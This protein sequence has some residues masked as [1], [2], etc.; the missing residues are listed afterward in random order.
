MSFEVY[1]QCFR[2]GK[3][4]GVP[5]DLI[6]P[7]F[8]VIE[9]ESEPDY[10]KV[11]YDESDWCNL[12]ITPLASDPSL[13]YAICAWRPCGDRRFWSSILSVMRLGA[14]ALYWPNSPPLIASRATE[15]ELPADMIECLGECRVVDEI[16][17]IYATLRVT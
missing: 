10:W 9:E 13:V 2:Q 3:P 8:P 16:D 4:A 12:S 11:F 5:R 14:I 7:L 17:E 1:L 6:K 15:A